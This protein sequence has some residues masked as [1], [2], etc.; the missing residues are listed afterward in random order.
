[1]YILKLTGA[2]AQRTPIYVNFDNVVCF[3]HHTEIGAT[4]IQ[5]F[6]ESSLWVDESPE[7]IKE[8]LPNS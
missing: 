5:I 6:S 7:Y 1:V 3:S 8:R 4:E 2:N